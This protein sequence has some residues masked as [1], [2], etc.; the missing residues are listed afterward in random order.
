ML[1]ERPIVVHSSD[2]TCTTM[3]IESL[4]VLMF[5]IEW[6]NVYIPSL[7]SK[8][9][10]LVDAPV[11]FLLGMSTLDVEQLLAMPEEVYVVDLDSDRILT[12]S[13]SP[14]VSWKNLPVDIE[15]AL[16]TRLHGLRESMSDEGQETPIKYN[17]SSVESADSGEDGNSGRRRSSMERARRI[18]HDRVLRDVFL[19]FVCHLLCDVL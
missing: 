19:R 5:P 7:P 12:R 1:L 16:R 17:A 10:D 2:S 8:M 15:A 9:S 18:F 13:R 14:P 11:P 6:E 4:R 3:F